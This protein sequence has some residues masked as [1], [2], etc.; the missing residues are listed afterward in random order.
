MSTNVHRNMAGRK[1]TTEEYQ[2]LKDFYETESKDFLLERLKNRSWESI[3]IQA[4]KLKLKFYQG[5][6]EYVQADLSVL[7]QET[8]L[9]YYWMGFISADGSFVKN[10]L[11]FCLSDKDEF[12][13]V[14]FC[15]YISCKNWKTSEGKTCVKIQ[16]GWNVPK[17]K[18]KFDLRARKTYFP[19]KTLTWMDS[20]LYWSY[21][22]GFIDGDGSFYLTKSNRLYFSIKCHKSWM[23]IFKEIGEK[24][25]PNLKPFLDQGYCKLQSSRKSLLD[26]LCEKSKN[27]RF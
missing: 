27:C 8:H 17:I 5:K 23:P 25:S 11:S 6:H 24:F 20:E 16:D 9:T 12:Q 13:V 14:K 18:D 1:W 4:S 15:E 22:V 3:K 21:L 2:I 19:P 7:L 26:F 10:R